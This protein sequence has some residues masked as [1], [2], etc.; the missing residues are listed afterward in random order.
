MKFSTF[1][2]EVILLVFTFPFAYLT[3]HAFVDAY[4]HFFSYGI[5]IDFK[6][7][8]PTIEMIHNIA[9]YGLM[10]LI[11]L[12]FYRI[13]IFEELRILQIETIA[14][15]FL[16]QYVRVLNIVIFFEAL[17]YWFGLSQF[18]INPFTYGLLIYYQIEMNYP[19]TLLFS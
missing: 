8:E 9:E 17:I 6:F 10:P 1:I 4:L 11:Y 15:R 16:I 2:E 12:I 18:H 13:F 3:K 5:P 19:R 14:S 7:P